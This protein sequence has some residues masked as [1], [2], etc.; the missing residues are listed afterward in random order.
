MF[1]FILH[2]KC[3]TREASAIIFS[4][5]INHPVFFLFKTRFGDW[6]LSPPLGKTIQLRLWDHPTL[7][8]ST[9]VGIQATTRYIHVH[10][11]LTIRYH[12]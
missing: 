3:D 5:H 11:N 8:Q 4:G 12:V 9:G 10:G 2:E 1:I 6:I 7:Q